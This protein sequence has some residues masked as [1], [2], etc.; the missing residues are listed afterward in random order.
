MLLR[1][2]RN[3]SIASSILTILISYNNLLNFTNRQITHIISF[4]TFHPN[5]LYMNSGNCEKR[6]L[7]SIKTRQQQS[8]TRDLE[9]NIITHSYNRL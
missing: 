6:A 9:L 8:K 2:H 7:A 1:T 5:K 4:F 3:F